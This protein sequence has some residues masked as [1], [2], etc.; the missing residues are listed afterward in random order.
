MDDRCELLCLDLD[1]AEALRRRRLDPTHA[2]ADAQR[3]HALAD[4]TR[5][6]LAAALAEAGELCVCDLA[7]I[8]ERSQNLVSHHLKILRRAGLVRSRRQGKMVM[9]TLTDAGSSLLEAV[10]TTRVAVRV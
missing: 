7:W 3:A 2:E 6:Q 9:Y 1:I 5:L 4:S 10:V 8:A